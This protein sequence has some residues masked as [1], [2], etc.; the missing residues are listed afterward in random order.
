MV[1]YRKQ[2]IHRNP[3]CAGLLAEFHMVSAHPARHAR[4]ALTRY[5][6]PESTITE[7]IAGL[8]V[9]GCAKIHDTLRAFTRRFKRNNGKN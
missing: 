9:I 8:A 3:N 6:V 7:D 4:I 1:N 2:S 5:Q